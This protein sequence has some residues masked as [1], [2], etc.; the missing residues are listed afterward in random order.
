MWEERAR[1]YGTPRV[2]NNFPILYE[3]D[4]PYDKGQKGLT[5][6]LHPIFTPI[7]RVT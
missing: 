7:K 5:M 2:H 1:I 4:I 3:I 6:I